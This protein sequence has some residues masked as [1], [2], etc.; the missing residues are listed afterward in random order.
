MRSNAQAHAP[1]VLSRVAERRPARAARNEATHPDEA[2]ARLDDPRRA[3]RGHIH[4]FASA[5]GACLQLVPTS[6]TTAY[7][8]HTNTDRARKK[9]ARPRGGQRG[10]DVSPV[11]GP[12]GA[13]P[14]QDSRFHTAQG[15]ANTGHG[16]HPVVSPRRRRRSRLAMDGRLSNAARKPWLVDARRPRSRSRT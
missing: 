4:P 1:V 11:T 8:H 3:P 9:S 13:E 12:S 5:P 16:W 10:Y 7:P 6:T 2:A 14:I 15:R